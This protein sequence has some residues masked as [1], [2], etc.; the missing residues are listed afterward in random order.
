MPAGM[1]SPDAQP[2]CG[3]FAPGEGLGPLAQRGLQGH[4]K[5]FK[6]L[7][8]IL[9]VV[10]REVQRKQGADQAAGGAPAH[11]ASRPKALGDLAT[12]L[13]RA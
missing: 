2:S 4:A 6:R 3:R 8:T 1:P 12:L 7:R 9:G 10:M 11:E 5:Q 13:A